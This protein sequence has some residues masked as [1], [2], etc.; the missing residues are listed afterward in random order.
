M[1]RIEIANWAIKEA[2]K[3]GAQAARVELSCI[4]MLNVQ[5]EDDEVST[6]QQNSGCGLVVRLFVDGRFGTY[7]TNRLE[8]DELHALLENGMACTRLLNQ[9][10]DRTLPDPQRY[11]RASSLEQNSKEAIALEN[12]KSF[13]ASVDAVQLALS[14][15]KPIL[16]A[17]PRL[18]HATTQL[19]SRNGWQYIA[20]T[21]G[22]QGISYC[23]NAYAYV[24]AS[25]RDTG[26]SRPSDGWM[27]AAIDYTELQHLIP[28]LGTKALHAAQWRLGASAVKPGKYHLAIEPVCLMKLLDPMLDAMGGYNLYMHRSFLADRLQAPIASPKLNLTEEPQHKGAFGACLFDLEGVSTQYTELI[29][30]GELKTY[31]LSTYYARKLK[32]NPTLSGPNVL[33]IRPGQRSRQDILNDYDETILITG[34]LGGNCNEVTGDFSFGI[35]GQLFRKGER[36]QGVSGMNI[37]GNMLQL[38][39]SI[40]EIANDV[41]RTFD[42][43]FP[44]LFFE[45]INLQ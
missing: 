26:D 43:Y 44:T 23:S 37:T 35:E 31:F 30:N 4:D 7:S 3:L 40:S 9:D 2:K 16:K 39:Q 12:Y 10:T 33:C 13:D 20:D 1:K 15:A 36:V 29:K 42:G 28:E 34:F 5:C 22:F 8:K 21:Q 45:N 17:D 19:G 32:K 24:S 6:L 27:E 38:W 25:L 14:I 41:E 11:Y 18:I